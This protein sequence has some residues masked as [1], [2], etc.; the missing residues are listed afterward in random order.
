MRAHLDLHDRSLGRTRAPQGLWLGIVVLLLVAVTVRL[1]DLDRLP[2]TDELYTALAARGWLE[3]GEPRISEGLY[4]RAQLYSLVMAGWFATFG[5]SL[6]SARAFSLVAGSLLVVAVFIWTRAVAGTPAG[7]IAGFFVALAPLS[8]QI[9]QYARFYAMHALVFWLAAIGAYS[10]VAGRLPPRAKIWVAFGSTLGFLLAA[11]L[12]IL[13]LIGLMGL[14]LWLV[15]AVAIPRLR[16]LSPQRRLTTLV[17]AAALGLIVAGALLLFGTAG[18]LFD[19]Y[20]W[21][22]MWNR[23]HQNEFW[24]YHVYFVERYPTFWSLTPLALLLALVHRPRPA[25]FCMC[26]F[27]VSFILVSLGGMKDERYL[28]FALPFLFVLWGMALAKAFDYLYPWM[29]GAADRVLRH[30]APYLPTRPVRWSLIAAGLVFLLASNGGV[31]KGLMLFAGTHLVVDEGGLAMASGLHR[32]NW[33]MAKP[34]LKP[35]VDEAS[36]ALTSRGMHFL[37]Y[38]GD[39]D[40]AISKTLVS[41]YDGEEFSIDERT[42]QPVVS[43]VDSVKKILQCYSDGVIVIETGQWRAPLFVTDEVADAIELAT[44]PVA[45]PPELQIKAFTWQRAS[46][47]RPEFCAS[48]PPLR[49]GHAG[50]GKVPAASMGAS[51]Q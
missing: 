32:T 4:T 5:D 34:T 28:F 7:W 48:L 8:V 17:V 10:L 6:V 45:M 50:S 44:R 15:L 40:F 19:R 42:G 33:P 18:E 39:Y 43:T 2:V 22:P 20:R 26:I 37:Y 16:A 31:V 24:F 21:A 14:G 1:V 23:A 13:T 30:L 47:T 36:V 9:S 3:E 46:D 49:E 25:I 27:V 29:T 51:E 35:L 11:H 41:E 38:V 12:Q